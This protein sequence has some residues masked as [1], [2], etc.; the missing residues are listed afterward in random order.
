M[1]TRDRR[2]KGGSLEA[3]VHLPRA[4]PTLRS[5]HRNPGP[6]PP[7]D[8]R[9][10][11]SPTNPRHRWQLR[12]PE[13]AGPRAPGSPRSA[14]PKRFGRSA[15]H[16]RRQRTPRSAT[17]FGPPPSPGLAW[18]Q[19]RT[20]R[21]KPR[22]RVGRWAGGC[23]RFPGQ[24]GST[25]MNCG[26]AAPR[27]PAASTRLHRESSPTARWRECVLRPR[28]VYA[29][30]SVYA[31]RWSPWP[32][33]WPERPLRQRGRAASP[34]EKLP[35]APPAAGLPPVRIPYRPIVP[36]RPKT[37]R[38]LPSDRSP[39]SHRKPPCRS[40]RCGH[41]PRGR[42]GRLSA[43]PFPR[44][45]PGRRA[46]RRPERSPARRTDCRWRPPRRTACRWPIR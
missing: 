14:P 28:W 15:P 29:P 44:S 12:V 33:C 45:G 21:R 17:P 32:V 41:S 24:D 13:R 30:R 26:V 20:R 35:S 40:G 2:W 46:R 3:G 6:T 27:P 23:D 34:C 18:R 5:R 22:R 8:R 4:P 42:P 38:P 11:R 43:V 31:L 9:T 16:A 25:A 36:R 7:D 10:I 37:S 19:A 39:W 1:R